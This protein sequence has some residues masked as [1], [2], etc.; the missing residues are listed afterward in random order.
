M[1]TTITIP[2]SVISTL[3]EYNPQITEQEIQEIYKIFIE[4]WQTQEELCTGMPNQ[5]E[6]W[7]ESEDTEDILEGL[8]L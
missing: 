6:T 4:I 7:L 8:G 2:V 5:F 3:R 1:K